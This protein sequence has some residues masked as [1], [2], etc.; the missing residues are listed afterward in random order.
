LS[1]K[2]SRAAWSTQTFGAKKHMPVYLWIIINA[3][4]IMFTAWALFFG[5]DR[6]IE[7]SRT[8]KLLLGF[9]E[10]NTD[11][12]TIRFFA[13]IGGIFILLLFSCGLYVPQVRN[14]FV[15]FWHRR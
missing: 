15:E 10:A 8:L 13:W 9:H 11:L 3:F 12:K 4:L 7:Q 1:V 6:R 2:K 14:F 5:G